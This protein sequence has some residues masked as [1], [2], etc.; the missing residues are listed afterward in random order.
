MPTIRPLSEAERR[1][2][3]EQVAAAEEVVSDVAG[4]NP[5][6]L[7]RSVKDILPDLEG[8]SPDA[9]AEVREAEVHGKTRKSLIEAID[10]MGVQ[11]EED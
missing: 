10:A 1:L 6:F 3:E 4:F 7:N 11:D 9:L 2:F 5:E 8:M